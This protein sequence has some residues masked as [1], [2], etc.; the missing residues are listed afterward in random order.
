M[1][2]K[3][4][5]KSKKTRRGGKRNNTT[6][7]VFSYTTISDQKGGVVNTVDHT[8]YTNLDLTSL[9]LSLQNFGDTITTFQ[10]T[11]SLGVKSA[12]DAVT[13][14]DSQIAATSNINLAAESLYTAFQGTD[15]GRTRGLYKAIMG[16]NT[17]YNPTIR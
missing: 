15:D 3:R 16:S 5:N 6:K 12:E 13:A 10:H 1:R 4:K 14:A 8:S 2:V 17:I 11:T 9:A 7:N